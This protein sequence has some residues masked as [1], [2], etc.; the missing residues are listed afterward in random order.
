MLAAMAE[1]FPPGVTWTRPKGG[2]FLWVRLPEDLDA[3]DLLP[4][5]VAE[6][7][8]FLAGG[9]FFVDGSGRNTARFNFSHANPDLIREGIRRIGRV[10]HRRTGPATL[11]NP[12]RF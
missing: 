9:A 10:L 4:D 12:R 6:K 2:L 5:A 7:V 8:V 1:C 3:A 11:A